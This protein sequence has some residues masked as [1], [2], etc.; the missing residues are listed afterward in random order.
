[1]SK[2]EW[3][4][5]TKLYVCRLRNL[6]GQRETESSEEL[7]TRIHKRVKQQWSVFHRREQAKRRKKTTSTGGWIGAARSPEME[8][9]QTRPRLEKQLS[10]QISRG[11]CKAEEDSK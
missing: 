3:R 8:K 6:N 1:V 4:K 2:Y 7:D 5:P 10:T 11:K 9:N